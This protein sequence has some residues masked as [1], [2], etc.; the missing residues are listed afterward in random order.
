MK[1]IIVPRAKS[2]LSVCNEITA[3][4]DDVEEF[5]KSLTHRDRLAHP[6]LVLKSALMSKRV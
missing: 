4:L 6:P 2:N 5:H 3:T 1:H